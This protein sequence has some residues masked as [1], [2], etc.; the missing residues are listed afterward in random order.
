MIK[1]LGPKKTS[2]HGGDYDRW[3][4]ISKGAIRASTEEVDVLV[5][6]YPQYALW[7]VTGTQTTE[8]EQLTPNQGDK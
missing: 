3:R 8:I 2:L 7:L 1:L 6:L 5:K 4:S